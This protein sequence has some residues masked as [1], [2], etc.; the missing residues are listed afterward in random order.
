MDIKDPIETG[1]LSLDDNFLFPIKETGYHC[2]I[3]DPF[4]DRAH[5]H[6]FYELTYC[7]SGGGIHVVNGQ[8]YPFT[9]DSVFIVSPE[10]TH[11]FYDYGNST[12]LT[13]CIH[14]DELLSFLETYGM[15]NEDCFKS[16]GKPFFIQVPSSDQQYL[17]YVSDNAWVRDPLK[18]TP[19][20]KLFLGHV[21]TLYLRQNLVDERPI[22]EAFSRALSEMS[23]EYNVRKG[24]HAFYRIANLSH[25]QLCRLTKQYLG[26]TPHEYVNSIRMQ[27]A[28]SYVT[29]TSVDFETIAERI[30]FSSY[31]HFYELFKEHYGTSPSQ[32]RK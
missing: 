23:L 32:L 29:T 6:D 5:R 2:R 1:K 22:P 28:Y 16:G 20:L 27:I 19:F 12:A 8:D 9:T 7:K 11:Y 30:G 25:S 13:I 26:M 14:P 17:K 4:S 18:R 3:V 31:S 10:D 24:V 21:L 15:E